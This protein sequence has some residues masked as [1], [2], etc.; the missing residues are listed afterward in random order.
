MVFCVDIVARQDVGYCK[1]RTT[2]RQAES[3][4]SRLAQGAFHFIFCL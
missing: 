2:G 3:L 4:M 1:I